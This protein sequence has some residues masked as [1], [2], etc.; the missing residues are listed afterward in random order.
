MS[1]ATIRPSSTV[2]LPATCLPTRGPAA[3][4]THPTYPATH[5]SSSGGGLAAGRCAVDSGTTARGSPTRGPHHHAGPVGGVYRTRGE[6]ARPA[7]K[8]H[9]LP[10]SPS[11]SRITAI[12]HF[13][14]TTAIIRLAPIQPARHRRDAAA[15]PQIPSC[16]RAICS[17]SA[18][19][20]FNSVLGC[21]L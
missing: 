18:F 14:T 2:K 17:R 13:T 4:T 19:Y 11:P 20:N 15:A 3:S 21:L 1:V 7:F 8:A 5:A 6:T 9:P 16:A 12:R 10:S